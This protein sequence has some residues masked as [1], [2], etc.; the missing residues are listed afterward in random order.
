MEHLLLYGSILV[1]A[2]V[3]SSKV[4]FRTGIPVLIIFLGIGM[5]SGSDGLLGI[6]FNDPKLTQWIGSLV[7]AIILFSGGLDTRIESIKVVKWQGIIL[8]T[9]GVI[10]ST[11]TV[12]LLLHLFLG[13]TLLTGLLIGSIISSTDAAAVF[14]I[15]R[16][17]KTGLKGNIRPLLELESGSNDPMAYFLTVT[18]VALHLNP[19][20]AGVS[21]LYQFAKQMIVGTIA[22]VVMGKVMVLLINRLKL[23]VEGLYPVLSLALMVF[24]FSASDFLHGNGFLSV[25]LAGLILGNHN[26]IHKKSVIKFFDGIAWISQISM[27][28][29]LGLLV[30]PT[31][32]VPVVGTGMLIA[33][34][35]I[36]IAR[37]VSVFASLAFSG[38]SIRQKIFI[39]WVGLR[40]AVPIVFATLPMVYGV[41]KADLIFHL[42][43]FV[44]F[45]SVA[46]QGTTLTL[47]AKLL[48][49]EDK[50]ASP[51]DY[52]IEKE[53]VD[54][55]KKD[56]FEVV[57]APDCKSAKRQIID[58]NFPK[59][60]LIVLIKRGEQ[61]ITP[62]GSTELLAG[63]KLWII[64]ESE[65]DFSSVMNCIGVQKSLDGRISS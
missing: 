2:A 29:F 57:I 10:L 26:F 60:A 35:L 18:L 62:N 40:G 24:T 4:S 1:L 48:G 46:L 9:I 8:S 41:E 39:S 61:L 65:K 49:V 43:F 20:E 34:I 15:L 64:A 56:L 5:L 37:P 3:V 63:D 6:P 28:I 11:L 23:E 13:F 36:F 30:F 45:A 21:V 25:Y 17:R 32:I 58:L 55:I 42:V 12:G 7:L 22:G 31:Q 50:T 16:S 53:L 54:Q 51:G 44:V 47:A 38:F 33:A 14:S 27:F 52:P 19:A 59:T